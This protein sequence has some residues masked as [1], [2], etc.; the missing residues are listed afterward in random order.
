MNFK[1][2]A[3][4]FRFAFKGLGWLL[5]HEN[6]F[7]IHILVS[8]IVCSVGFWLQ[9]STAEWHVVLLLIGMMLATEAFNSAIEQLCDALSPAYNPLIGRVKDLAA[10]G[11]LVVAI[12]AVSIGSWIFLPKIWVLIF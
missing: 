10:A 8:I 7:K 1:K 6:N 3:R 2:A 11:V 12:T 9:I 4:S 5:M